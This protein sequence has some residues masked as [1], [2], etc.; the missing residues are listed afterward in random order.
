MDIAR[1]VRQYIKDKQ[2]TLPEG[3]ELTVWM[4]S[5]EELT[6]RLDT[7]VSTAVGGLVLVLII[8]TLFLRF[9]LALWVAAGIPIAI[10]GTCSPMWDSRS[11]R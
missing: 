11:V 2:R 9:R 8:L 5:S 7:L 10:A 3:I 1:D 6:A 4:D